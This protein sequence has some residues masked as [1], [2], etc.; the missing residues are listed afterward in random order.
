MGFWMLKGVIRVLGD[1]SISPVGM[2]SPQITRLSVNADRRTQ[3]TE[4]TQTDVKARQKPYEI[5]QTD[6]K[7]DRSH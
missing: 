1:A 3:H 2:A 7:R 6:V 4:I 5:T